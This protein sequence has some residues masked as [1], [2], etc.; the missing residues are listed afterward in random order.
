MTKRVSIPIYAL[1]WVEV[2]VPDDFD[3]SDPDGDQLEEMLEKVDQKIY[4][5]R[6]KPEWNVSEGTEIQLEGK[7]EIVEND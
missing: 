4:K 1:E 2:E 5:L 3:L 6:S 7:W